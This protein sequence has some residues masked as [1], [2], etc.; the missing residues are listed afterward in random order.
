LTPA[1]GTLGT[2]QVLL[3]ALLVF[4]ALYF[5]LRLLVALP[6]YWWLMRQPRTTTR[7]E[8]S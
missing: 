8:A 4:R 7:T 3:G 2:A 6:S 5:I 1:R